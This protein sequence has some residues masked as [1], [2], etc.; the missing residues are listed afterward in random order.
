MSRLARKPI[1]I[2]D[3]ITLTVA[4]EKVSVKGP[5]G[6]LFVPMLS[7]IAVA[8]NGNEAMVTRVGE[9]RQSQANLGTMWSLVKNAVEG[10][11]KG[12]EKVLEI[13]GVGY[14]ATMEG[15]NLALALGY[16][17]PIKFVPPEG[18]TLA[19]EK[20]LIRIS[21]ASKEMVGQAAALIRKYRKPE[22]YKGKGI[23]YQGE[24][25]R[26][27]AGKKAATK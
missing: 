10:A 19:L 6:E 16:S 24:V 14:R 4:P 17:H 2:T 9:D 18:V 27:K 8:V 11:S 5:K 25:V 15:Q 3:G 20:N 12:F 21:G 7:G 26:M 23:R 13:Q 1:I 22:P